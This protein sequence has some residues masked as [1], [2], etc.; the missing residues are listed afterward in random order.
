EGDAPRLLLTS[1]SEQQS[2]RAMGATLLLAVLLV[3]VWALA[4]FPGALAW[5]RTFWP[6]QMALLGCL[7]WQT[8]GPGL[9]LLFLI[10]LGVTARVL[11]LARR[12]LALL[13]RPQSDGSHKGSTASGLTADPRPSAT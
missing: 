12:L 2:K 3:L 7:G 13:H 1:L 11:F 8:Y 10:V 5:V 6:E 9:P 4:H